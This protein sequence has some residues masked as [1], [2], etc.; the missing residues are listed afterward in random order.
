MTACEFSNLLELLTHS[1]A[2]SIIIIN[3]LQT[4]RS[5]SDPERVVVA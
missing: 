5:E 1:I 4:L 3:V 2:T